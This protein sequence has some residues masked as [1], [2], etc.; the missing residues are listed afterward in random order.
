MARSTVSRLPLAVQE[1]LG[2]R[3]RATGYGDYD[4]H[5]SWLAERGWTV[6]RSA[7]HRHGLALRAA[8]SS[9]GDQFARVAEVK[10]GP[11]RREELLVELGRLRLAEMALIDRLRALDG[12]GTVPVDGDVGE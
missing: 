12:G 3:L 6:S 8:D 9:L 1:E 2:A 4:A 5:V 7:V 10:A 11:R